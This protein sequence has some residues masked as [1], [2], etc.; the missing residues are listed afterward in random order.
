MTIISAHAHFLFPVINLSTEM[1]SATLI[2]YSNAYLLRRTVRHIR[3]Y[4][5][6]LFG[7]SIR[8]LECF[9]IVSKEAVVYQ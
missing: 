5:G 9:V 6:T 2:Y 3:G 8:N 7:T 1:D 4:S